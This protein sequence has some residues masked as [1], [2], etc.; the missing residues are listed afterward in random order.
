MPKAKQPSVPAVPLLTYEADVPTGLESLA[1]AEIEALPQV[2]DV[3]KGVGSI[4]FQRPE[5]RLN[6]IQ[7]LKLVTA[8]YLSQVYPVPR[9]KALLGHQHFQG[10]LKQIETA[11]QHEPGAFRT[12]HLAA[13]G[14]DSSV[15]QRIKSEISTAT[16]LM[17]DEE[18]GDLW[19][20]MRRD[21]RKIGWE[22]LVRTSRRPLVTRAWRVHDWPGAV[23]AVLAQAAIRLTQPSPEDVFLNIGSGS[24]TILIERGLSG[25]ARLLVGVENNDEVIEIAQENAES[26]PYVNLN[27]LHA[28]G[29]KLPIASQSVDAIAADLPFG[30]L[31]GSTERNEEL[32]PALLN[33]A[34]RVA[35]P[36][37]RFV[38]ITQAVRVMD[39]LL[40]SQRQWQVDNVLKV[41]QGG[42]HPR[43]YTLVRR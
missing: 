7:N 24:G 2:Y 17:T 19:I 40:P 34:A 43:L 23:N 41:T 13:A 8:V 12:F 42:L 32:Y 29:Q 16:G 21:A 6:A 10:L 25:P 15:M 33:E 4:R 37:A 27:W 3:Q 5:I 31:I 38:I 14:D 36:G 39:S 22:V 18:G 30:V 20:R 1:A 11:R 26:V 35:K 9:P 28:D